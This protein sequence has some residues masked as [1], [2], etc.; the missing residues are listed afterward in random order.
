MR[1][2]VRMLLVIGLALLSASATAQTGRKETSGK[3]TARALQAK[4][5]ASSGI[6]LLID[7]GEGGEASLYY[8]RIQKLMKFDLVGPA[9]DYPLLADLTKLLSHFGYSITAKELETSTPDELMSKLPNG[10][11]ASRFFAPKIV[12]Y[13]GTLGSSG[14]FTKVPFD[15]GWRK[16]VRLNATKDSNADNAGLA[17]MT[18]LFNY[19]QKLADI[20]KDPFEKQIS[21]NNQV[22]ITFKNFTDKSDSALFLVFDE[23]GDQRIQT[24]P[25]SQ[26]SGF[27]FARI[28]QWRQL[29]CAPIMRSMPWRGCNEAG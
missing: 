17:S 1:Q 9:P 20:A 12:D 29:F 28:F 5:A 26:G 3:A 7:I 14:Q 8:D 27:R 25:V 2:I 21:K 4:F 16:L 11:L 23:G 13:S 15:I 18:V 24:N 6:H 10:V 19:V 22:I